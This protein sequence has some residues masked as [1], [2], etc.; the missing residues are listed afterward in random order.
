MKLNSR[1]KFKPKKLNPASGS[2]ATNKKEQKMEK[3]QAKAA[4]GEDNQPPQTKPA[5]ME[6]DKPSY[7]D[8]LKM[9]NNLNKTIENLCKQLEEKRKARSS[10]IAEIPT[11]LEGKTPRNNVAGTSTL[12]PN[13]TTDPNRPVENEVPWSKVSSKRKSERTVPQQVNA[14][15]NKTRLTN[16]SI[17]EE[18]RS[19]NDSCKRPRVVAEV[20]PPPQYPPPNKTR[21]PPMIVHNNSYKKPQLR[22]DSAQKTIKLS[23]NTKNLTK[24]INPAPNLIKRKEVTNPPSEEEPCNRMAQADKEQSYESLVETI[25]Q[26]N[27]TII[28]LRKQLEEERKTPPAR[29]GKSAEENSSREQ[30]RESQSQETDS[31]RDCSETTHGNHI[32]EDESTWT[33]IYNKRKNSDRTGSASAEQPKTST[34]RGKTESIWETPTV[35]TKRSRV[36]GEVYPIPQVDR[37]S[38]PPPVIIYNTNCKNTITI[39]Q[40]QIKDFYLKK[41]NETKHIVYANNSDNYKKVIEILRNKKIEFFTYTPKQT[42]RNTVLLKNL[43]GDFDAKVILDELQKIELENVRFLPIKK[44]QTRKSMKE[45]RSLPIYIAQLIPDSK[46]EKLKN[47][48]VLLHSLVS[49]EK[50][51][52]TDR[53]QCRRC[54]R[55]GHAATNCNLSY[56]CVKCNTPHNPGECSVK[57]SDTTGDEN[58]NAQPYCV[59]CKNHGHP[60]SYRGCPKI[61]EIKQ[62]IIDKRTQ[63]KIEKE[64]NLQLLNKFTNPNISYSSITAKNNPQHPA[65]LQTNSTNTPANT[66]PTLL[67]NEIKK[68][69]ETSLNTQIRN[70]TENIE[71]NANKINIIAEALAYATSTGQKEFTAELKHLFDSLQLENTNH[72]FLLAGDL[73]ARHTDW[74]NYTNNNRGITLHRWINDNKIKY[75]LTLYSTEIPSFPKSAAFIDLCLADDRLKIINLINAHRLRSCTYDSD[76]RAV[77]IQIRIDTLDKLQIEENN[78]ETKLNLKKT[79]WKKFVKYLTNKEHIEIQNNRNLS[80]NEIDKYLLQLNNR[81]TQALEHSTPN[82]N[83]NSNSTDKYITQKIK[84]LR[85]KKSLIITKIKNLNRIQN[86]TPANNAQITQLKNHLKTVRHEIKVAFHEAVNAYWGNKVKSISMRNKDNSNPFTAINQIFRRK[87]ANVIEPLKIAINKT[88]LIKGADITPNPQQTGNNSNIII[89]NHTEKLNILGAHFETIHATNYNRGKEGLTNIV[90]QKADGIKQDISNDATNKQT[91]CTFSNTNT[92]DNPN[93]QEIPANYFTN[94]YKLKN[95][96]NKLNNK[97]SSSFDRIPNIALKKLPPEYIRHYTILFN[98]CLNTTHYPEAWKTAKTI[99]LKKKDKDGTDPSNYRPICLLP[100][101]SKVFEIIVNDSITKHCTNNNIIPEAQFGFRFRHSTIH[102]I[103]KFTDDICWARNAEECV[104]AILID[105]EKAFDSVWLDGLFY[106][107]LKKKNSRCT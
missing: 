2:L 103:T 36:Q 102:A 39:L 3:E 15:Q 106:K 46:V 55:I 49:W 6:T 80:I 53:L 79:D 101:I 62:K 29:K 20:T 7:V 16:L 5:P 64:N 22:K 43:E 42:K 32:E 76:H 48:K 27:Q 30:T 44:F 68:T 87:E 65:T 24:K 50:L 18:K 28:E 51:I 38:K 104:G 40:T 97:H 17:A 35:S 84:K 94:Y 21:P 98:N 12:Q 11:A 58:A 57:P 41:I 9:I 85:N 100:N 83:V 89:T 47:I 8:L 91:I 66:E 96:F 10:Q 75:R 70:I 86:Y 1:G 90:K 77:M 52:K 37:N 25:K 81:I 59:I 71:Q 63:N 26:L 105:L 82:K 107:L 67:L 99:P 14:A 60:A 45:G 93:S 88:D 72:Y 34:S 69:I 54:Q 73:N 23:T 19:S 31:Q 78:N 92:V 4:T 61:K 13:H 74:G 56:R 95:T 33:K